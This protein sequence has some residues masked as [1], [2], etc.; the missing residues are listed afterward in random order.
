[1]EIFS[2]HIEAKR[3][4]LRARFGIGSKQ[5]GVAQNAF[6]RHH[7]VSTRFCQAT[8]HVALELKLGF[9]ARNWVSFREIF[10]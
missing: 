9:Y 8:I 5:F 7:G 4:F 1:M 6:G 2:G 10:I 3:E